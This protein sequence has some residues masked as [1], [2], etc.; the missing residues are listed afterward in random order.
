MSYIKEAVGT[1]A[2][3]ETATRKVHLVWIV[4]SLGIFT[5]VRSRVLTEG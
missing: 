5:Q 4:R 1:F 2:E 3:S